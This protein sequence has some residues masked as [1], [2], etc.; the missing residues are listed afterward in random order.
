MTRPGVVVTSRADIPPRSAPTDAGMAFMVGKTAEGDDVKTVNSMTQY[1]NTFGDR[2]G[3]TDTYD[4]AEAFFTEGGTKITVS[5]AATADAAGTTAALA[6][7]TKSYGPGQLF[8]PSAVG[9]DA[10][11]GAELLAHAGTNNRVALLSAA[12]DADA[13]ALTTLAT[14]LSGDPNARYGALFAPAAIGPGITTSPTEARTVPWAVIAAGIMSRNAR[15]YSPNVPAAGVLGISRWATDLAATFTDAEREALNEDGV[16]LARNVYGQI[17]TYGYRTLAPE[18][19]GWLS[20]GNARLNMEIVAKA[21]AIGERYVFAQ[22]DG[23][24]VKI[25][26]F[27]ADLSSMLVPYY[28]AGSLFGTTADDAFYVDVG[29]SVN[30]VETIAN[31]ELHAVI[32]LRMSPFAEYVVIEIVKVAT[33][34]SLSLAA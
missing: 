33:D 7:L 6:A 2:T 26:Q 20:L 32:G 15:T 12:P 3:A 30:T 27:G 10:A 22:I 14:A 16:D 9:V 23:R 1:V 8:V 17:Q 18:S 13:T 21:E 5:P 19:S 28:D 25:S 34:Q 29:S 4:A 31:G 11:G 24:G